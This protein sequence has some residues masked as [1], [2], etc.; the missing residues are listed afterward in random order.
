M[1]IYAHTVGLHQRGLSELIVV[2]LPY[3]MAGR[4]L[5][6]VADAQIEAASLGGKPGTG[7]LVM[8]GMPRRLYLLQVEDEAA[9]RY[10]PSEFERGEGNASFMQMCW[11]DRA[12]RFPCEKGFDT[13]WGEQPVL[14]IEP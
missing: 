5:N 7:P 13:A 10:A 4:F 1:P 6:A 14:G 8:P 9:M 2:G 12:G 3:Q 11:S